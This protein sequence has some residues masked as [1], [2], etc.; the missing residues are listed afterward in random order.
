MDALA[1]LCNLYGDGP[2]T[3]K[4]LRSAGCDTF[5]AL[6][7]LEPDQLSEILGTNE[8]A[9]RRFLR[10]ARLLVERVAEGELE[11][12][13]RQL[14]VTAPEPAL[15]RK[16]PVA[17]HA[18]PARPAPQGAPARPPAPWTESEPA[19]EPEPEARVEPRALALPESEEDAG[20]GRAEDRPG[21][22]EERSS[23][24]IDRVLATWRERDARPSAEREPGPGPGDDLELIDRGEPRDTAAPAEAGTAPGTPLRPRL[25]GGLDRELCARLVSAGFPT[26]EA[27]AEADGLAV[28]R[29]SE[30]DL[31]RVLRLQFL[32]R[33]LLGERGQVEVPV[34]PD[35]LRPSARPWPLARSAPSR[36]LAPRPE[37]AREA[38]REAKFSA[39]ERPFAVASGQLAEE[40]EQAGRR[41]RRAD[42]D[43]ADP[44]AGPGGPFA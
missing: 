15:P 5:G 42:L 11:H 8:S 7:D 22:A 44:G 25:V 17:V 16:V 1:L 36:E 41:L 24:L 35:L 33:R 14:T 2:A 31:T 37:P 12:E 29:A 32:A 6:E 10:E 21:S 40:L 43:S 26:A 19:A 23:A 18:A 34:P 3:L 39:A 30:V 13:E 20:A 9:A 27:L 28:A 4:R 38:P